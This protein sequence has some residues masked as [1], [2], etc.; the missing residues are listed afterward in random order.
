M[1]ALNASHG[2]TP[3]RSSALPPTS[4]NMLNLLTRSFMT[5]S[6]RSRAHGATNSHN[7]SVVCFRSSGACG[8]GH[9]R[10]SQSYRGC[11]SDAIRAPSNSDGLLEAAPLISGR[12]HCCRTCSSYR[13]RAMLA[14][15]PQ[16][17]WPRVPR[18]LATLYDRIAM[19][20]SHN[21]CSGSPGQGEEGSRGSGESKRKGAE[22]PLN[23]ECAPIETAPPPKAWHQLPRIPMHT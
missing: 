11:I 16:S 13:A 3:A 18:A 21:V 1:R 12:M 2:A 8:G 22:L 19:H 17:A 9:E 7:A 6:A 4:Q 14:A 5:W 15:S 10:T 20:L 23:S